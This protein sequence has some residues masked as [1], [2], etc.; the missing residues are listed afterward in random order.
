MAAQVQ[1]AE[2]TKYHPSGLLHGW[3]V[4]R[5]PQCVGQRC[6]SYWCPQQMLQPSTGSSAGC[7]QHSGVEMRAAAGDCAC[8]HA[9]GTSIKRKEARQIHERKGLLES[10]DV[11]LKGLRL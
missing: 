4:V 9:Q 7:R 8:D 11:Q 10:R 2:R 5:R 3:P 6:H 1:D